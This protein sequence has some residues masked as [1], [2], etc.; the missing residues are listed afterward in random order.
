MDNRREWRRRFHFGSVAVRAEGVFHVRRGRA[1]N[2]LALVFPL[3]SSGA[4]V[5]MTIAIDRDPSN[6]GERWT[7]HFSTLRLE[8]HV[9]RSGALMYERVGCL[10]LRLSWVDGSTEDCPQWSLASDAAVIF[11][12]RSWIILPRWCAPRVTALAWVR[13]IDDRKMRRFA[14]RV[15]VTMP[16]GGMVISYDGFVDELC[17]PGSD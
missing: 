11:L 16:W 5:P 7:R 6:A 14:T 2:L 10:G 1:G 8:S 17:P 4:A 12:R 15:T 9:T 3:P 13:T